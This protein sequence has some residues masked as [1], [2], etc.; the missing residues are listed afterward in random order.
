VFDIVGWLVLAAI[1][2]GCL[3]LVIGFGVTRDG[4]DGPPGH[5]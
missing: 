3:V 5:R 4:S 1:V 2:L